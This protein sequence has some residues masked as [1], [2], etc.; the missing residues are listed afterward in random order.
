M[1]PAPMLTLTT[2]AII[3]AGVALPIGIAVGQGHNSI[4][5]ASPA[6]TWITIA[7]HAARPEGCAGNTA[8][9][10]AG[11]WSLTSANGRSVAR[12]VDLPPRASTAEESFPE[13]SAYLT[14]AIVRADG[15]DDPAFGSMPRNMIIATGGDGR[16]TVRFVDFALGEFNGE[17]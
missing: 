5:K 3:A 17:F 16:V 13:V 8:P 11:V 12:Y 14:A 1:N 4:A 9:Y 2:L 6:R 15:S 10:S 7:G